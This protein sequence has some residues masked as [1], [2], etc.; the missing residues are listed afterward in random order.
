MP[1]LTEL[2]L[3]GARVSSKGFATLKA[4]L[5]L[6]AQITCT[7]PNRTAAEAVLALG[8]SVHIAAKDQ[9]DDRAVKAA[10]DLPA[11]YFQVTRV[12]LAGIKQPLGRDGGV[13]PKLAALRDPHWDRLQS[14]DLSATALGDGDLVQLKPL[15]GL[16]RLV[17]DG[18][19][20][21]NA[22]LAHLKDLP[23][24]TELLLART[25]VSDDGLEQLKPLKG[26]RVLGLDGCP[27]RGIGLDQLQEL[28]QLTELRLSCPTLTNLF[29]APLGE[30]KKLERLS[31]AGSS[32]GDEGLKHLHGLVALQELDL[33]GTKVMDA[34]ISELRKALPN[35]RIHSGPAPK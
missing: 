28:P 35:C 15:N 10:A 18:T 11:D 21:T 29:V 19:A 2:D 30:L 4:A 13:L 14:L 5:P 20:V 7:E 8:G 16:H 17:L 32:V 23:A 9:A 33:T 34:G 26:L 3:S 24:L 27:I 12:S 31:L 25:Q 22:G 1:K 6:E